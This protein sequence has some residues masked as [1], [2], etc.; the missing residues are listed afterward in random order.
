MELGG[1]TQP[2]FP[3]YLEAELE[4]GWILARVQAA[5]GIGL[6]SLLNMSYLEAELELGWVL[7]RVQVAPWL[8]HT[9]SHL[10]L[11]P[12]LPRS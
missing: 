7:T 6:D 4:L 8:G 11:K 2:P 12:L 3:S 9:T 10:F 5:S 1:S